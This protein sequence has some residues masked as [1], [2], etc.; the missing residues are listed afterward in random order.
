VCVYVFAFVYVYAYVEVPC[1]C[2]TSWSDSTDPVLKGSEGGAG[3][4]RGME[5]GGQDE[6]VHMNGL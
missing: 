3:E 1:Q 4:L 2:A 5:E 6:L